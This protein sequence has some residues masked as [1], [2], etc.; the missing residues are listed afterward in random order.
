MA[1]PGDVPSTYGRVSGFAS[2]PGL[3]HDVNLERKEEAIQELEKIYQSTRNELKSVETL[4]EEILHELSTIKAILATDTEC[5]PSVRARK[6]IEQIDKLQD[7]V[8]V[9]MADPSIPPL[10]TTIASTMSEESVSEQRVSKI[11]FDISEM[12]VAVFKYLDTTSLLTLRSVCQSWKSNIDNTIYFKQQLGTTPSPRLHAPL[13]EFNL[14][15][16]GVE[17]KR[18]H[19]RSLLSSSNSP[20]SPLLFVANGII[21]KAS[22]FCSYR[23]R[24]GSFIRAMLLCQPPIREFEIRVICDRRDTQ[25]YCSKYRSTHGFTVG[26]LLDITEDLRQKHALCPDAEMNMHNEHGIVEPTIQ[27]NAIVVLLED[28]PY[29]LQKR[30]VREEGMQWREAAKKRRLPMEAFVAAKQYARDRSLLPPTPDEYLGVHKATKVFEMD[31]D[32][33]GQS[34]RKR[35]RIF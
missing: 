15:H 28:D 30:Q 23:I 22:I 16:L 25:H 6:A 4:L 34:T 27:F 13:S 24:A 19:S 17:E 31:K 11:T 2:N 33:S 35:M 10:R 1:Y 8:A 12:F 7:R 26:E 5:T 32:V 29:L 9:T 21:L 20:P 14:L 18:F 3:F